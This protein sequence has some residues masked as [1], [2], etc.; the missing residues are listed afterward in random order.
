M[1]HTCLPRTQ[2]AETGGWGVRGHP[3][4]HSK[5][6]ASLGYMRLPL[7]KKKNIWFLSISVS[8]LFVL[9][10]KKKVF[11]LHFLNDWLREETWKSENEMCLWRI[12][13]FSVILTS[14]LALGARGITVQMRLARTGYGNQ[15]PHLRIVG[16]TRPCLWIPHRPQAQIIK[17]SV[18]KTSHAGSHCGVGTG[19]ADR[20][21]CS[22]RLKMNSIREWHK[23]GSL[24]GLSSVAVVTWL[25]I[26]L[27]LT[28]GR[29]FA[30]FNKVEKW[31]GF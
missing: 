22:L 18:L 6:Q 1:G 19:A 9:L 13:G 29:T 3:Q 21:L 17:M 5:L 15:N 7:S 23:R 25:Y 28:V 4:L 14:A 10:K 12:W 8:G 24:C 16:H 11:Y 2:K 26:F 30:Y 27:F 31:N 20:L